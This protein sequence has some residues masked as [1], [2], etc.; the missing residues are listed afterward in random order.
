MK[1]KLLFFLP[2]KDRKPWHISL[3]IS[4]YDG[5]EISL[6]CVAF[7][8]L[9]LFHSLFLLPF[10]STLRLAASRSMLFTPRS[11][12][13]ARRTSVDH[14]S[15]K[16]THIGGRSTRRLPSIALHTNDE[17]QI[18]IRAGRARRRKRDRRGAKGR[19]EIIRVTPRAKSEF[20]NEMCH[21]TDA[22]AAGWSQP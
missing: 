6:R 22:D 14:F 10:H 18:S 3:A 5:A 2:G 12:R 17:L 11:P 8:S 13:T 15:L 19:W 7:F 9:S 20:T 16:R 1:L 21:R 4:R